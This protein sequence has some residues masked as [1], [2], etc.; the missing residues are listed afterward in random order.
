QRVWEEEE[1]RMPV[2]VTEAA[3]FK[4]RI[5]Q[6]PVPLVQNGSMNLKII[7]E[8]NPE[9]AE[10]IKIDMLHN[11]PGVNSSI[12]VSIAGDQTEALLPINAAANAPVQTTMI[13]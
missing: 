1:L 10:P 7:A 3:P 4:V 2:V 12:S 13:A 11:P 6:P 9:F 8:R 5:E